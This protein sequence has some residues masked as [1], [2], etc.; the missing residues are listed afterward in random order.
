M[1]IGAR[2]LAEPWRHAP[3]RSA[4]KQVCVLSRYTVAV[5]ADLTETTLETGMPV[6]GSGAGTRAVTILIAFD[7][8]AE[9]SA[10]RR[11]GWPIS[12][13]TWCSRAAISSR[14][15]RD[16]N[17]AAEAIGAV[18][19]AYTSHDLVAFHITSRA[20]RALEAADLLTDWSAVPDRRE[21]ARPRARRRRPGDRPGQ[22]SAGGARRAP[23]RS[24]GLR[25]RLTA[26]RPSA[27]H[28]RAH[29]RGVH[30]R[31]SVVAFRTRRWAPARGGAFLVGNLGGLNGGVEELFKRFPAPP[32]PGPSSRTS[33]GASRACPGA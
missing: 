1:A 21:G 11:T 32:I 5:V 22:R 14:P 29:R 13:S 17:Q 12:S 16:V 20:E 30:A 8:G 23:D 24:G 10:P 15:I 25:R 28:R 26:G 6:S 4:C 7:A 3:P 27:R 31:K 2:S 9:P 19:N 18:L 33:A